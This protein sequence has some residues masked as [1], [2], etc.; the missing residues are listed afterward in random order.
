MRISWVHILALLITSY[1]TRDR[2]LSEAPLSCLESG[3]NNYPTDFQWM[4]SEIL[5]VMYIKR[6]PEWRHIVAIRYMLVHFYELIH[7]Y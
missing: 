5:H 2:V 7:C 1:V 6:L 3:I 4:L